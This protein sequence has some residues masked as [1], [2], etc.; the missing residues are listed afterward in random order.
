MSK[1]L[2]NAVTATDATKRRFSL[3]NS[4]FS[5]VPCLRATDLGAGDVVTLW[6]SVTGAWVDTALKLDNT[7][8][9]L[10]VEWPGEYAVSA[11]VVANVDAIF[12]A[13]I[14]AGVLSALAVTEA[15]TGYVDGTGFTFVPGNGNG[16]AL[17]T[18]DVVSGSVTNAVLTTPGTGYTPDG[19]GEVLAGS[20][21][22]PVQA[23]SV[24]LDAN[25][26]LK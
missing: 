23:V 19:V 9:Y 26:P 24:V 1:L 14:T 2:I 13:T 3:G 8:P 15:G 20:P 12:T 4:N 5:G 21:V 11:V 6:Q 7:T 17:V 25:G 10:P 22:A 16:D 18:Y